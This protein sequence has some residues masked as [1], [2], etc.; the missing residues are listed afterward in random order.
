MAEYADNAS[1][2]LAIKCDWAAYTMR[3]VGIEEV[4]G[5]MKKTLDEAEKS[6]NSGGFGGSLE[7][8]PCFAS[9]RRAS[10]AEQLLAQRVEALEERLEQMKVSRRVLMRLLENAE[11]DRKV[12]VGNLRQENQRLR[13][14]NRMLAHNLWDKNRRIVL[15]QNQNLR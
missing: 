10:V 3:E 4:C 6:E 13:L 5:L 12:E 8:L 15:L 9:N 7:I 14:Q 1:G 2:F 11:Q